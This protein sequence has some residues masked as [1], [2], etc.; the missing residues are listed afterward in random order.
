MLIRPTPGRLRAAM[1]T[2]RKLH[3]GPVPRP[4][5]AITP[6]PH[7]IRPRVLSASLA[8]S[9]HASSVQGFS[10]KRVYSSIS[11][12]RHVAPSP[13]AAVLRNFLLRATKGL[14]APLQR[15]TAQL[16]RHSLRNFLATVRAVAT[17][18]NYTVR[19]SVL[20]GAIA[21]FRST[22]QRTSNTATRSAYNSLSTPTV[23]FARGTLSG[24]GARPSFGQLSLSPLRGGVGLQ[25]ARKFSSGG[26]R[27]FD[28]LI[29]NAPLALRLAGDEVEDK[30]KMARR[31]ALSP[32]RVVPPSAGPRRTGVA[33]SGSGLPKNAFAFA[34]SRKMAPSAYEESEVSSVVAASQ[35]DFESELS[36][37]FQFPT[38]SLPSSPSQHGTVLTIR[39]TDGLFDALGGRHPSPP[40]HPTAPRLFDQAFLYD[41]NTALDYED[42]RNLQAK[43]LLRV[44]WES[45]MLKGDDGEMDLSYPA[46]WIVTITGVAKEELQEVLEREL[47][48]EFHSWCT[49]NAIQ[50]GVSEGFSADASMY[51]ESSVASSVSFIGEGA[52]QAEGASISGFED[53]SPPESDSTG[54]GEAM[55]SPV[56][57]E[58]L[59]SLPSSL[60]FSS[61]GGGDTWESRELYDSRE[62]L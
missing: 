60:T 38:L 57:S 30:A 58:D 21:A 47:S 59:M 6:T 13:L 55:R 61:V 48:F 52:T 46:F 7:T 51:S 10:V 29:V 17:K 50:D 23:S 39:M 31:K 36:T 1:R 11:A 4:V 32:R 42:K 26:S 25:S 3:S 5:S 14:R 40:S 43:A 16:N 54:E 49:I 22:A 53:I 41:A 8:R 27:V 28:N 18:R 15:H 19:S 45:G 62:W 33:F 20:K 24:I 9:R 2:A 34:T 35:K 12:A 44:L 37:Y 56:T